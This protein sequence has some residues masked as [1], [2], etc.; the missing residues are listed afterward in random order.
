MA[1]INIVP[2]I[3]VITYRTGTDLNFNSIPN[4]TNNVNFVRAPD[5]KVRGGLV[6][7]QFQTYY[8]NVD[9]ILNDWLTYF[10]GISSYIISSKTS[11]TITEAGNTITPP[12]LIIVTSPLGLVGIDTNRVDTVAVSGIDANINAVYWF[13]GIQWRSYRPGIADALNDLN[14]SSMAGSTIPS[15]KRNNWIPGRTYYVNSR[16]GVAPYYLNIPRLLD[17]ILT[18]NNDFLLADNF[19]N[20]CP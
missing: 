13:D 6:Y 5:C 3:N 15:S 9:P 14:G 7:Q 20:L 2:G 4:F 17:Y 16:S 11:F 10:G 1:N 18:D 8:P 12:Q 19:D